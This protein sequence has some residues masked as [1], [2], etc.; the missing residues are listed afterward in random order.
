MSYPN[1]NR[2]RRGPVYGGGGTPL[3]VSRVFVSGN[4]PN[5]AYIG[6]DTPRTA[7]G[8]Y[9]A[10]VLVYKQAGE[11]IIA[12]GS[13]TDFNNSLRILGNGGVRW[14][15]DSS[16]T[17][18]SLAAGMVP[19]DRLSLIEVSRTGATGVVSVNSTQV[20]SGAVPTGSTTVNAI[21]RQ[22]T[23]YGSGI[24]ANLNFVSGWNQN[25]LFPIDGTEAGLTYNNFQPSDFRTFTQDGGDWLSS[26]PDVTNTFA[27]G[28]IFEN[29]S[30]FVVNRR[31]RATFS[32][33]ADVNTQMFGAV[34]NPTITAGSTEFDFEAGQATI[35]FNSFSGVSTGFDM[36]VREL[37]QGA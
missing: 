36:E 23:A 26:T 37:L 27:A 7:A 4:P 22:S 31:Y 11:Q 3:P 19:D 33:A 21:H 13:A 16:S 28:A 12:W 15:P 2:R 9:V 17:Q 1:R 6:I 24:V 18:I 32:P 14:R 29:I 30:G 25:E 5:Q 10:R 35:G 20:F 8:D 34:G